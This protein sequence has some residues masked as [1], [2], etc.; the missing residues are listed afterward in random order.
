M[1]LARICASLSSKHFQEYGLWLMIRDTTPEKNICI[2]LT[3]IL[4]FNIE[5]NV[6]ETSMPMVQRKGA[7]F[8][9]M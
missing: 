4:V 9:I 8:E 7:L 2:L 6:R 1:H 5:N 3:E